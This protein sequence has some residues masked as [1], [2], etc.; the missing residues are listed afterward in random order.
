MKGKQPNAWGLYDM[1]GNVQQFCS[2]GY[3]PYPAGPVT[4]PTGD[5]TLSGGGMVQRGGMWSNGASYARAASRMMDG[6]PSN[7]GAYY[8]LRPARSSP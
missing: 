3:G 8:G 1:L 4:D 6:Y 2:D 5:R 7:R